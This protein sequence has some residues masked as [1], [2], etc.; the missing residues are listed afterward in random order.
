MLSAPFLLQAA[1]DDVWVEASLKVVAVALVT[2][3]S[4][5]DLAALVAEPEN[6]STVATF[7]SDEVSVNSALLT[8]FITVGMAILLGAQKPY[9]QRQA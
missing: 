3:V 2:T 6:R 9:K 8:L 1:C 7:A 4:S 5:L